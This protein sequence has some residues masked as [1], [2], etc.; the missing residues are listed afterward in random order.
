M[1]NKEFPLA[2]RLLNQ[3]GFRDN[4]LLESVLTHPHEVCLLLQKDQGVGLSVAWQMMGVL[5]AA[6]SS[7]KLHVVSGDTKEV[8]LTL[9]LTLTLTLTLA[10]ALTLTLTRVCGRR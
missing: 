10:L 5:H 9:I 1:S 2:H 6:A 8:T 7:P 3:R 4:A